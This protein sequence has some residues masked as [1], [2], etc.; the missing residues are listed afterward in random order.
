MFLTSKGSLTFAAGDGANRKAAAN[1]EKKKHVGSNRKS[2]ISERLCCKLR[3]FTV[4]MEQICVVLGFTARFFM[5]TKKLQ[6][7]QKNNK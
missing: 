7:Q 1:I 3:I 2:C 5:V 4:N 6:R